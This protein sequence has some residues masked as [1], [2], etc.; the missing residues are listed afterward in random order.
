[1]KTWLY[2]FHNCVSKWHG[3]L[4]NFNEWGKTL[5]VRKYGYGCRARLTCQEALGQ[6]LNEGP[7]WTTL[8]LSIQVP[9][10]YC[11]H[12]WPHVVSSF[13]LLLFFFFF[14]AQTPT[15]T[16]ILEYTN[17]NTDLC[18]MYHLTEIRVRAPI[19]RR[20]HLVFC[21][22]VLYFLRGYPVCYKWCNKLGYN[23]LVFQIHFEGI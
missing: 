12:S 20:A 17:P 1:M 9:I 5:F 8:A 19:Q 6:K 11:T 3:K 7:S 22:Q 16:L 10:K 23:N 15:S 2:A 21:R 14:D 4:L 18:N 13:L